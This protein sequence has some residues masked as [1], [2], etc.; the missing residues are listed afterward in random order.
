MPTE[1]RERERER[2]RA[3]CVVMETR[4]G[5][6]GEEEEEDGLHQRLLPGGGGA[7]HSSGNP[8]H[9]SKRRV[10]AIA[11]RRQLPFQPKTK[12]PVLTQAA[13]HTQSEA[14]AQ[15]QRAQ[16]LSAVTAPLLDA[17]RRQYTRPNSAPR[18]RRTVKLPENDLL[19]EQ[20]RRTS[21]SVQHDH[22]HVID[23]RNDAHD[24]DHHDDE[25]GT[26]AAIGS[27]HQ[28]PMK[29]FESSSGRIMVYCIAEK[30]SKLDLIK[31]I[32]ESKAKLCDGIAIEPGEKLEWEG[33]VLQFPCCSLWTGSHIG[34][35]FFFHFGV[36]VFWGFEDIQES[37]I[38]ESIVNSCSIDPLPPSEIEDEEFRFQYTE[39]ERPRIQ[40]DTIIMGV[41]LSQNSIIKLGIVYP[42]RH[43]LLRSSFLQ[44][45][46]WLTCFSPLP[47]FPSIVI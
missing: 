2:E 29:T 18:E 46:K 37:I 10:P 22:E 17:G 32:I 25:L 34:D 42:V 33:D 40:N 31:R 39:G 30:F 43:S 26:S 24:E 36:V 13:A 3:C 9:L 16:A 12:A 5:E 23:I 15:K 35:I 21:V 47:C 27:N 38:L 44:E 1:E 19:R 45:T 11:V 4:G 7:T 20:R 41:H 6:G 8:E 14:A 28:S